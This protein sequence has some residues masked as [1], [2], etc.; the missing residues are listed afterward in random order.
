MII[1]NCFPL[2]WP[3][4][5]PISIDGIHPS[6]FVREDYIERNDLLSLTKIEMTRFAPLHTF[7]EKHQLKWISLWCISEY[8]GPVCADALELGCAFPLAG[9]YPY[10]F[11]P[12]FFPAVSFW[13]SCSARAVLLRTWPALLLT[14][15]RCSV[16][17]ALEAAT[18]RE[19]LQILSY[20][21]LPQTQVAWSL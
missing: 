14:K 13:T 2:R 6:L 19:C 15:F 8:K 18:A 7:H 9:R 1:S 5:R 11:L 21:Y 16:R 3:A 4:I 17:I 10:L 20:L 12:P